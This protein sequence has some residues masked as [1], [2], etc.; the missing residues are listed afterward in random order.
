MLRGGVAGQA[1]MSKEECVTFTLR[2][3]RCGRLGMSPCAPT[4]T[5]RYGLC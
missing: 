4:P 1:E 3:G 5:K 2:L